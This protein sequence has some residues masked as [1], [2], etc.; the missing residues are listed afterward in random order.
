MLVAFRHVFEN[1]VKHFLKDFRPG[2]GQGILD[3]SIG[4]A[5]VRARVPGCVRI[6]VGK[7]GVWIDIA[8]NR[9]VSQR[10]NRHFVRDIGRQIG[11]VRR[12]R[13]GIDVRLVTRIGVTGIRHVIVNQFD[14]GIRG[15]DGICATVCPTAAGDDTNPAWDFQLIVPGCK[16]DQE[17]GLRMRL[18][19]KPWAGRD[20]V[21]AE[22]RKAYET[23]LK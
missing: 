10:I 16:A 5:G 13:R 12:V 4:I 7:V 21:I 11:S 23:V 15:I 6:G 17:Y 20:D 22:V 3:E 14:G 9:G 18:V 19:Y 2:I 8:V 1:V